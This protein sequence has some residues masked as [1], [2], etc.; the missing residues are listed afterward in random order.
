MPPESRG[1]PLKY[2]LQIYTGSGD[3]PAHRPEEILRTIREAACRLPVSR[4]ILGWCADPAVY[5][6]ALA[7]CRGAGIGTLLWLPVFAEGGQDGARDRALDLSGRPVPP[8]EGQEEGTFVF[9]CPASRRNLDTV[10]D[11]YDR[12]FSGFGFDGVFLD[13]IRSQTFASGVAGV[14]SCGCERCRQAF[15]A[16]GVD[17]DEVRR[18]YEEK[19]DAFFDMADWPQSG[20]FTLKEPAAQR[21]FEAKEDIIAGAAAELSR[22][23]RDRGLAVGMDLFAPLVSRFAGQNY[24]LLAMHADFIKPM[25][26]RRTEAPAGIGFE[27]ALFE[28]HAPGAKGRPEITPDKAFL[29]KQLEA[30]GNVPCEMYA[31]IEINHDRELVPTDPAYIAESLSAVRDSGAAG[32]VLSWDAVS[33]PEAHLRAAEGIA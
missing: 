1:Y 29:E 8:P 7:F 17:I 15:L 4:V 14:L 32:A 33:A 25:L 11:L 26:Y 12:R 16:R 18:L 3:R 2:I 23:F 10:T 21:F 24:A 28:K 13:R 9:G 20:E 6:Q 30:A 31:G 22:R 5:D 27:Y 19:G